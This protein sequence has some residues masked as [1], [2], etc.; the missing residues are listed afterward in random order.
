LPL[1]LQAV[2]WGHGVGREHHVH[3]REVA[4]LKTLKRRLGGKL[5]ASEAVSTDDSAEFGGRHTRSRVDASQVE[6]GQF[7]PGEWLARAGP[8]VDLNS[9]DRMACVEYMPEDLVGRI[10]E[11]GHQPD[12]GVL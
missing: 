4:E 3:Q 12:G 11:I 10:I 6:S 8:D 1:G 5:D 2:L 7:V 9:V